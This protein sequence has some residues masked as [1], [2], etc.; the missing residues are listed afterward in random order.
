MT[1]AETRNQKTKNIQE[2]TVI[3]N[4][5]SEDKG[6]GGRVGPEV[7]LE[8]GMEDINNRISNRNFIEEFR[9]R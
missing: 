5:L 4:L 7:S 6:V 3:I 1:R 9:G 2:D 8:V